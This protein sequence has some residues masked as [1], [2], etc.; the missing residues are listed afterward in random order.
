MRKV[1]SVMQG[2]VTR[3]KIPAD[4]KKLYNAAVKQGWEIYFT[5]SNHLRWINPQ[6]ISVFTPKSP[7]VNGTGLIRIIHKLKNAGLEI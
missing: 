3:A 6:G 2:H 5:G 4:Y 7:S 1:Y